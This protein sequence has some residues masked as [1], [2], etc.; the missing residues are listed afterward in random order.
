MQIYSVY[1]YPSNIRAEIVLHFCSFC[2]WRSWPYGGRQAPL[3]RHSLNLGFEKLSVVESQ[4][5]GHYA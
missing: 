3:V 5:I 4:S 2:S 1:V